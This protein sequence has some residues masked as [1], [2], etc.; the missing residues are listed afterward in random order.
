MASARARAHACVCLCTSVNFLL[1]W[2]NILKNTSLFY[3]GCIS[4]LTNFNTV[5]GKV[6]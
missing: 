4:D 6:F 3:V 5:F 1:S 2:S